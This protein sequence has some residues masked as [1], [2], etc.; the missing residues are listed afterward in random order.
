MR[1]KN[2]YLIELKVIGKS[3]GGLDIFLVIF[4]N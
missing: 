2:F 4:I 1:E 3:Y